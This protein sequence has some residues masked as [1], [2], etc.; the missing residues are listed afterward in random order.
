MQ[1]NSLQAAR[2]AGP[3]SSSRPTVARMLEDIIGCK[4][5]VT[6]LG[7][8]RRGV[9]R[10]GAIERAV[11]GLTTKVMN[12]RL[13]KLVRYRILR[14]VVFPEVPPHVEYELTEFGE[15]FIGLLDAVEA[16]EAAWTARH[17]AG[18]QAQEAMR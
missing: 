5:S 8:V 16:L 12:E 11:D 15:Q 18:A 4:W 6:I 9:C 10:P 2:K 14:R 1:R 13:A 17:P 3:P 7:L